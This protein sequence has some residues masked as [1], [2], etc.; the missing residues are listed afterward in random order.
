MNQLWST[1][2]DIS[3]QMAGSN[4]LEKKHNLSQIHYCCYCHCCYHARSNISDSFEQN[5]SSISLLKRQKH[6]MLQYW[7]T[8]KITY[9]MQK[10]FS[11]TMSWKCHW[12]CH[13][14]PWC[15]HVDSTIIIKSECVNCRFHHYNKVRVY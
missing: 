15:Y 2:E 12:C 13:L 4:H 8:N 3:F 9:G 1:I 7:Y 6:L 11:H 10:Q 5:C 14:C